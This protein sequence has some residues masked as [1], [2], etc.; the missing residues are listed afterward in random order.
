MTGP[1]PAVPDG[2]DPVEVGSGR[3]TFARE[4]T[5]PPAV[6]KPALFFNAADHQ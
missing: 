6:E 4:I 3:H 5:V 1:T 2:S